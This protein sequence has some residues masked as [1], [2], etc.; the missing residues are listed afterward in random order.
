MSKWVVRELGP[1]RA[2]ALHRLPPRLQAD[3]VPPTPP[4]RCSARATS[5][6]QE[7]LR[8]VYTGNVRDTEGG[9][10]YCPGCGKG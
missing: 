6:S 3:E 4:P 1:R 10:T 5:P 9:T 2:D 8:Y 7:G